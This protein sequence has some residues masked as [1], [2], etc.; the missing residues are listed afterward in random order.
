MGLVKEKLLADSQR[1]NVVS[2]C[3]QIV[4]NQVAA[5]K[6]VT[7]VM[8]KGGY[9]AF[10]AIKPG[11]VKEAVEHL[12]DDFVEVADGHYEEYLKTNPD[13]SQSFERWSTSRDSRIADDLLHVTDNI[14]ER[15]DK[16][17]LKKIYHGMRKIAERNVAQAVP[18]VARLVV[19]YVE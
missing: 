14:I 19:K 1:P 15:S 12:L 6:G 17:A 10:K 11:I 18:D 16:V 9:K 8:I 13:K 2:D 4:D 5:K 3:V 7:G